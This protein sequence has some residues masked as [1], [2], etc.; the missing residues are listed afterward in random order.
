MIRRSFRTKLALGISTLAIAIVVAVGAVLT[1]LHTAHLETELERK[2]EIYAKLLSRELQPVVA[3]DDR[4]TARDVFESIAFDGDLD[5]VAV[6]DAEGN[7]IEGRGDVARHVSGSVKAVQTKPGSRTFA[8]S[9]ESPEGPLG[10]V[11]V[12]LGTDRL[13]KE[14]V[15]AALTL[16][17]V[18]VLAAGVAYLL[19]R[20][21]AR[22]VTLRLERIA[23]AAGRVASGDLERPA[24]DPGSHDE[25]GRLA[26]AFN[27]MVAD[28]RRTLEERR[29]I[30]EQRA[31]AHKLES[32]GRLASGVAHEINTPVQF[33]TDS[34]VFVRDVL[35]ELVPV[36]R[37]ATTDPQ[38]AYACDEAPQ[39]L[40]LALDGLKRVATIVRSMKAYAHPDSAVSAPTGL[41]EAVMTTLTIARNELKYVAD[42]ETELGDLPPVWCNAG[43]INQT[44]LNIVINAAHAIG[45][46]IR[47]TDQRGK[48]TV[49]T[50]RDGD[51]AVIS[52]G[53]TGGGIP[54][55]IR[56]RIFDPFFTTKEVGKGTGQG[57]A[58]AHSIVVEKHRG[59]LTFDTELGR[60]TT[61]HI[62]L[63]VGTAATTAA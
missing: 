47:G 13:A 18:A 57:L 30:E 20:L 63:P 21:Y 61:F 28:L 5:A 10:G 29:Q 12:R 42:L 19:A 1:Q 54:E 25:V 52:I 9:V 58:L 11:M 60:G 22:M 23:D 62:R 32:V 43:E 56:H 7:L 33:V 55:H 4:Q 6:Y 38:L 36:V 16:L 48:L 31:R 15:K 24:L 44:V 35:A 49:T 51:H 17:L 39:A 34:V 3:F 53:D 46:R 40:E 26:I 45:D 8:A 37:A 59:G 50:R 41:N 14:R 27:S 2:G